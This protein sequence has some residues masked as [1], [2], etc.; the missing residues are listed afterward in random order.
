MVGVALA[1]LAAATLALAV[2][3]PRAGRDK[4]EA[5]HAAT[6]PGDLVNLAVAQALLTPDALP[7]R[8]P[9][10]PGPVIADAIEHLA[11]AIAAHRMGLADDIADAFTTRAA[12]TL[13][14]L[15][16]DQLVDQLLIALDGVA[17]ERAD[18]LLSP[19]PQES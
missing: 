13:S 15:T 19:T 2:L 3:L 12:D 18:E 16:A 10:A 9:A 6:L 14:T 8:A 17:D 7:T 5:T 1:L 4:R 11:S